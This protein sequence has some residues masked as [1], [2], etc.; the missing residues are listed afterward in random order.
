VARFLTH[1]VQDDVVVILGENIDDADSRRS[2]RMAIF[3]VDMVRDCKCNC[4][5]LVVAGLAGTQ[6][7]TTQN[8]L[9]ITYMLFTDMYNAAA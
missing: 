2:W 4:R 3:S 5:A 6:E 9:M 8:V 7:N 1:A